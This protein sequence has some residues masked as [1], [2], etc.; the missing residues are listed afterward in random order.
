MALF[1]HDTARG[2]LAYKAR[3]FDKAETLMPQRLWQMVQRC[4][5]LD[6]AER[7]EVDVIANIFSEMELIAVT[8][9]AMLTHSAPG[10]SRTAVQ[11]PSSGREASTLLVEVNSLGMPSRLAGVVHGKGEQRVRFEEEYTTVQFG[12]LQVDGISD[13]EE[14]V[15][16]ML[17][18]LLKFIRMDVLTRPLEVEKQDSQHVDLR[19][20]S[21]VEANNFAMTWMVYRYDPH[22]ELPPSLP[23]RAFAVPLYISLALTPSPYLAPHHPHPPPFVSFW[24]PLPPSFRFGVS[25]SSFIFIFGLHLRFA[26]WSPSPSFLFLLILH[27][28]PLSSSSSPSPI[29]YSSSLPVLI[30]PLDL[31]PPS[32]R[33]ELQ[34]PFFDG[35]I[36]M[37]K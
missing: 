19:F 3:P 8:D 1:N 12:P 26:S 23:C 4:F 7:P 35:I 13:A 9:I 6:A 37:G 2:T 17:D 27:I 30:F 32:V 28:R 15:N 14:L 16:D 11:M 21:P 5:K 36:G 34:I 24:S 20:R 31:Q 29:P 22:K 10:R 25:G 18:G 33:L